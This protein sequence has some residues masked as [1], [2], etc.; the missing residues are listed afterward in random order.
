MKKKS[1]SYHIAM[2]FSKSTRRNAFP[3]LACHPPWWGISFWAEEQ[4]PWLSYNEHLLL[5]LLLLLPKGFRILVRYHVT[6]L[7]C[8]AE[9]REPSKMGNQEPEKKIREIKQ[10]FH[11]V[12][13]S[14]TCCFRMSVVETTV[15]KYNV[16]RLVMCAL[17]F[18][19][20]GTS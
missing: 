17:E 11:P 20:I 16:V 12:L 13:V 4:K 5:P 9:L 10:M 14:R 6:K 8:G 19:T 7:C 15:I 18:H 1:T 2:P 3:P